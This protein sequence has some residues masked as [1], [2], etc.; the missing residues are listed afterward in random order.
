MYITKGNDYVKRYLAA[1]PKARKLSDL[2]GITPELAA[3][4]DLDNRLAI[5][6]AISRALKTE[7]KRGREASWL[8]DVNRH[9]NLVEVLQGEIDALKQR[10]KE[11]TVEE[12]TVA[13]V[14][15][16]RIAA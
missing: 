7:I 13:G 16:D 4:Q 10:T 9:R 11:M 6:M 14:I 2:L 3:D 12:L 8:Y 1:D 5:I 15:I